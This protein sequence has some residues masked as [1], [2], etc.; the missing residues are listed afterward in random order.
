M[1]RDFN[2]NNQITAIILGLDEDL[3]WKQDQ[4]DK[5]RKHRKVLQL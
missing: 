2:I 1:G 4:K 5:E 3:K